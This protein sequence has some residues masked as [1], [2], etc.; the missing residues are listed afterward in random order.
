M[1]TPAYDF[2]P[3]PLDAWAD[4]KETLHLMCQI[5]GKVRLALHPKQNHWWHVTLYVDTRGLTTRPIPY[6]GALVEIA[7]DLLDHTLV[8][9]TSAGERRSIPLAGLS[10][11]AFYERLRDALGELG[12]EAHI[13]ARPY[14]HASK[15]PFPEDHAHAAYDGDAVTRYWHALR[16]IN[17]VFEV[18]RGRFVG[19][20][21]PVHLFWHSFD[22]AYTRFSGKAAPME[23][24]TRADREAYSHEV[25][26]FGFWAG[27][28][29]MPAPAFYG[30]AYPEPAG[31][32]DEK[33]APDAARWAEQRG[34]SMA[35]LMYDD[36]RRA[37]D[38]NGTLL[39]FLESAYQG[40][41]RRAG[42][43]VA[44]LAHRYA[45]G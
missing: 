36:L 6:G 27:D 32:R 35:L 44:E 24:G 5:V 33:L 23:G 10:V 28:D 16:Q 12:V 31:L 39:A 29:S 11:A 41:A 3:L 4:S 15:T 20:A 38:P 30:Y 34:G 40:A 8:V 22:L 45:E 2:P 21:T 37:A 18:F 7:F 9:S 17:A 19:K 1:P 14:D 25:I 42:W 43:P 13:L 26:S